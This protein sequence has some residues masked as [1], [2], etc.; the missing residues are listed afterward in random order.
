MAEHTNMVGG[1]FIIIHKNVLPY[2]WE[3]EVNIVER[4]SSDGSPVTIAQFT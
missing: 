2:V 3:G 4:R 1:M